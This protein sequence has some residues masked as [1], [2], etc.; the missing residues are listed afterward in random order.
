M[1]LVVCLWRFGRE[2]VWRLTAC[3][4]CGCLG[5][6]LGFVVSGFRWLF[7]LLLCFLVWVF[8]LLF[9]FRSGCDLLFCCYLL[10][11]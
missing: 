8:A 9:L 10:L 11:D 2:L 5:L 4:V 7:C 3:G 6:G 1:W